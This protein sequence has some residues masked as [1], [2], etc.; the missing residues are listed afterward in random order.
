MSRLFFPLSVD[1]DH[2]INEMKL[3]DLPSYRDVSPVVL[4]QNLHNICLEEL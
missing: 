1:E 2:W 3:V 4:V